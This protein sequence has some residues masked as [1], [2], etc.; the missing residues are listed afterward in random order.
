MTNSSAP[1]HLPRWLGCILLLAGAPSL[2]GQ[3]LQKELRK[4]QELDSIGKYESALRILDRLV[5]EP[6]MRYDA[7]L[8][9]QRV[10]FDG[11]QRYEEAMVQASQLIDAYPDSLSPW[12]ARGVCYTELRMADRAESDLR[13]ALRTCRAAKDSAVVYVD[14]SAAYCTV[15]AYRKALNVLDTALMLDPDDYGAQVNQANCLEWVGRWPEAKA[16][17]KDLHERHPMDMAILNNLGFSCSRNNEH[18]EALHWF[19]LA[20]ELEPDNPL[21]LNNLG[22]AQLMTGDVRSAQRNVERSIKLRPGNAYAYRNLAL[23]QLRNGD[24]EAACTAMEDALRR[25]FTQQYGPEMNDLRR[26]HCR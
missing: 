3:D 20:Q 11:L 22:Y 2:H 8:L 13:H 10:L 6:A 21:V 7:G 15:Q 1:V 14:L 26:Q 12:V 24:S 5:Q 25:G 18:D 19:A 16:L 4:A 9:R 17:Y 23:I